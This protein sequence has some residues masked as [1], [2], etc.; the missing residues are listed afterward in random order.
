MIFLNNKNISIDIIIICMLIILGQRNSEFCYLQTPPGVASSQYS[1]KIIDDSET[2]IASLNKLTISLWIK[3]FNIYPSGS[4]SE[5]P[6]L[7][8]FSSSVFILYDK[9]LNQLQFLQGNK[10]AFLIENFSD[11]FNKWRHIVVAKYNTKEMYNIYPN[12]FTFSFNL[13]D[14]PFYN[15]YTIPENGITINQIDIG[16]EVTMLLANLRVYPQF[17]Q[18]FYGRFKLKDSAA[19]NTFLSLNLYSNSCEDCIHQTDLNYNIAIVCKTDADGDF[20]YLDE[21][22]NNCNYNYYDNSIPPLQFFDISTNTCYDCNS[23]CS[24]YCFKVDKESCSCDTYE[25][26]Y[27]LRKKEDAAN[28]N[29]KVTY[30]EKI[31]YIDFS[32]TNDVIIDEVPSSDTEEYS[33]EFWTYLYTY[34]D[35]TNFKGIYIEWNYHLKI[36]LFDEGGTPKITCYPIFIEDGMTNN[37]KDSKSQGMNYKEW[38]YIRCGATQLTR[39]YFLQN[40]EANLSTKPMYFPNLSDNPTTTLKFYN[41]D[42]TKEINYGFIFIREFKLW[43]QYNYEYIKTQN[44]IFITQKAGTKIKIIK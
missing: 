28:D 7:I 30:C 37:I 17:I 22:L 2:S 13:I 29:D 5:Q 34:K 18:G 32:N 43:R 15:G 44:L 38:T 12:K 23:Y 20:Y 35:E 25:Q 14:I 27:W 42:T 4:L 24:T 41:T 33:L 31:P 1:F 39:K 3:Y 8:Y 16:N 26:E 21:S 9:I 10:L 11:H 6:K 36:E 40:Q 19:Q